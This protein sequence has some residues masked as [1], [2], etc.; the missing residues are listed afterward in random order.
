MSYEDRLGL[1]CLTWLSNIVHFAFM[2]QK[3]CKVIR[4]T[5]FDCKIN[6]V[7]YLFE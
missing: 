3:I 6:H 1:K 5:I 2:S 4:E 7:I